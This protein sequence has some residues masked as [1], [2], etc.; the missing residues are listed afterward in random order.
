MG[1]SETEIRTLRNRVRRLAGQVVSLERLLTG[2]DPL[3]GLT[4]VDAVIAAAKGI[5]K[6]YAL[7]WLLDEETPL[8]QSRR[9]IERV[10]KKS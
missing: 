4:Q 9:I 6:E 3:T 7:L 1:K 2:D 10:V 5:Q 8:E